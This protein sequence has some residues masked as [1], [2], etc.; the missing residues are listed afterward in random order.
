MS[1][2]DVEA[3]LEL[4]D[5]IVAEAPAAEILHADSHTVGMVVEQVLEVFCCP[6]V[7][8]EHRLTLALLFFLLIGELS[9]VD[10]NVVF[11]SQP[12]QS[13]GIGHLLVLH[14][15]GY[16]VAALAASKAVACATGR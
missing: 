6:F 1:V 16:G 11:V 2:R 14:D 4:P 5:D 7:D 10:L 3:Q 15:K 9:F 12:A 8:D 13:L